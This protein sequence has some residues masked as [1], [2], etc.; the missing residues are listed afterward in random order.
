M[1]RCSWLL[2]L[3]VLAGC[4]PSREDLYRDV[5]LAR[6]RAHESWVRERESEERSRVRLSGA[7][8]VEDAVKVAL[9]N[10]KTLLGVVK[11]REKAAG[12]VVEAYGEALPG[13]F[14]SGDYTHQ[15]DVATVSAG[16]VTFSQ[17]SLDSYS[18]D[19]RV[20]QPLYR[21]GAISA[22]MR[23]ARLGAL[24]SDEA[25]RAAMQGT[26][27]GVVIDYY[28]VLLAERLF[29]A[30][31]DAVLSAAEVLKDVR[32]K[33]A[34]GLASSFDVLRA[35]VDLSNFKA[36][37]IQQ[38]NRIHLARTRLKKDMGVAQESEVTLVDELEYVPMKPVFE[39]AVAIAQENRPDLYQAELNVRIQ[40]EVLRIAASRYLPEISAGFTQRWARPDPRAPGDTGDWGDVWFAGVSADL[41]LFD[42]RREG[43]MRTE[44]AALE[45]R[46]FELLDAEERALLEVKQALLNL[47]DAEEFVESQKLVLAQAEEA[48]R[49][50]QVGY[51]EGLN[52]QVEV[53]DARSSLT[54]AKSLYFEAIHAHA[55]ARLDLKR[56]MGI[57]GPRA[58][59]SSG[60][61]DVE[62]DPTR[63]EEFEQSG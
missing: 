18:V 8:T 23:A 57:L 21:G 40:A 22:Q 48:L 54:R 35:E 59:G 62:A 30:N 5:R 49:L 38:K 17:G 41:A 6:V 1:K 4:A 25:V 42:A 20:V 13:L 61:K 63:I 9:L 32:D 46:S 55:V 37:M 43:R 39:E 19:L 52:S 50:V 14:A 31:R 53:T 3:A 33:K 47:A 58:G 44:R 45:Q 7:L 51:K 56:A 34:E 11:E 16:P 29:A 60:P 36:E 28:E 10:N 2:A 12:G 24:M 15:Q 26:I 27:F